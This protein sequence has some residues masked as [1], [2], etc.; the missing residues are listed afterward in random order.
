MTNKCRCGFVH[1]GACQPQMRQAPKQTAL[2]LLTLLYQ[3]EMSLH[4]QYRAL[5]HGDWPKA[6]QEEKT[7]ERLKAQLI[8]GMKNAKY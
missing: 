2:D 5:H 7:S 3:F 1:F 6:E 4:R 8:E